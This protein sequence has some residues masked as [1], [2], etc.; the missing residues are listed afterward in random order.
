[1]TRY[2]GS[3]AL[4]IRVIGSARGSERPEETAYR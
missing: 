4:E 1:M 3:L 2:A